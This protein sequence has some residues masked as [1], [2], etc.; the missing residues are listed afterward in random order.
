MSVS[1][2]CGRL[3]NVK[4]S[5]PDVSVPV[6]TTVPFRRKLTVPVGGAAAAGAATQVPAAETETAKTETAETESA[7]TAEAGRRPTVAVT[8]SEPPTVSG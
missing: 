8:V 1:V 5:C 7:E 6:P 2:P 4:V 3:V